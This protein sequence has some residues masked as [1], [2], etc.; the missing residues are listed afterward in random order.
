M[1]MKNNT[2]KL[3]GR[4]S[5]LFIYYL[6]SNEEINNRWNKYRIGSNSGVK[7]KETKV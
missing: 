5:K 1:R 2:A 6:L 4:M 7:R 3:I